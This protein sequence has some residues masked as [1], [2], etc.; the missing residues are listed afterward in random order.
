MTD[1]RWLISACESCILLYGTRNPV[2]R[3]K[4]SSTSG[5]DRHRAVGVEALTMRAEVEHQEAFIFPAWQHTA[6]E[7]E[8]TAS[9]VDASRQFAFAHGRTSLPL[10]GRNWTDSSCLPSRNDAEGCCDSQTLAPSHNIE[11]R[12]QANFCR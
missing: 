10:V 4:G 6:I 11:V 8:E 1:G 7:G 12:L 2:E 5:A 9:R 3:P